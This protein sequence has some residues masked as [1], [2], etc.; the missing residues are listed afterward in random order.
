M[1]VLGLLGRQ[2]SPDWKEEG[3]ALRSSCLRVP[4]SSLR[5][6]AQRRAPASIGR[7]LALEGL[8]RNLQLLQL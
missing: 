6:S 2:A 5:P 3:G 1:Q 4:H 7:Q 8:L